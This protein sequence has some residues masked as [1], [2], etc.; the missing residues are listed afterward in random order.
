LGGQAVKDPI[1]NLRSLP[2]R[3][4]PAHDG[5]GSV[6][7]ARPLE[8]DDFETDLMFI[9][10][11]EVPPG[12]TIGYHRHGDDEEIYFIIEGAGVMEVEGFERR[13]HSGDLIL[14]RRGSAHG[15][16]NDSSVVIRLLVWQV[17]YRDGS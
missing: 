5:I 10:Y 11:V 9:E 4:H 6:Q 7:S 8:G 2:R 12:A 1:V 17:R 13:V 16:V 14:N 15:L 3:T